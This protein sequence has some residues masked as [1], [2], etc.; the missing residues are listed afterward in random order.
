MMMKRRTFTWIKLMYCG[1]LAI[2]LLLLAGLPGLAQGMLTEPDQALDE[3]AFSVSLEGHKWWRLGLMGAVTGLCDIVPAPD[4]KSLLVATYNP[5]GFEVIWKS[6]SDPLGANW[7][8]VLAMNTASDRVILRLSQKYSAD[9]TIYAA[10]VDGDQI[11]LSYNQG[12]SWSQRTA[13]G[14]VIDMAVVNMDTIYVALPN[15]YIAKST[16]GALKWQA[17]VSTGLFDIHMVAI[18][19]SKTIIIGGRNGD[20]AYS[21]DGGASFIQIPE[22]IDSG[23]VQVITDVNYA[24]N[25]IIYASSSNTIYRWAIGA[26][27]DWESIGTIGANQQ[28]SGLAVADGVLYGGW[29]NTAAAGSGVERYLEPTKPMVS[30]E[31]DTMDVGSEAARFDVTPRSPR[32]STTAAG[33]RLWAIDSAS[34]ALMVYDDTLAKVVPTLTFPADGATINVSLATGYAEEIQFAWNS[35]GIGT[36]LVD[37]YQIQIA[38]AGTGFAAALT[39]R[40]T[41]ASGL[42]PLNPQVSMGSTGRWVQNLRANTKY[43]WRVR[44]RGQNSG[45]GIRSRWSAARWFHTQAGTAVQLP[46]A[47]PILLGPAAGAVDVPLQPGF[48]WAPFPGAT[49]YEFI[50]ATDAALTNTIAGTPVTVTNPAFQVTTKLDYGTVYIWAVRATKPTLGVQSIGSFT[51]VEAPAP[52]PPPPVVIPPAPA[53]PAPVTSGS[54][55]VMIGIGTTL[56]IALLVLLAVRRP[57]FPIL[58]HL[59][60]LPA[61]EPAPVPTPEA[62][63]V[64]APTVIEVTA[65]ELCST[66]KAGELEADA[67]YKGKII[68]VTGV[69]DSI[70]EDTLHNPY[71][72]LTSGGKHQAWGVRCAFNK[73]YEP[74]LAQL[75]IGQTVTVQGK[76]D[77]RLINVI[78][79]DCL[80]VR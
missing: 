28:I 53:P 33:V 37:D 39:T 74:E 20:V 73:K 65:S 2:L 58:R 49:E 32:V 76:C 79:K 29:Y 43:E 56:V 16:D 54:I 52:A 48:S 71:I 66:Y 13:P 9:F 45:D 51:T 68:K 59:A 17:S 75:T 63:S 55:W 47:G 1:I 22:I 70:G 6:D 41:I 77:G 8:Q 67:K 35:M 26:S 27:S 36:S 42:N 19:G 46:H 62:V 31:Y 10:E 14:A 21:T 40:C 80:L 30:L 72:R 64:P 78:M 24:Q 50:L 25:S 15:G 60:P 34:P 3:T 57:R 12:N 38:I 5:A 23:N 18:A 44:A 7:W 11:A 61:P 4:S 69:V